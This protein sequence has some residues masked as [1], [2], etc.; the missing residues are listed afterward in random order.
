MRRGREELEQH[1]GETGEGR[2]REQELFLLPFILFLPK[3]RVLFIELG[4]IQSGGTKI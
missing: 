3:F 1:Y 2:R 4:L